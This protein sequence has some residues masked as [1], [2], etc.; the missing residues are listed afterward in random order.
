LITPR[1]DHGMGAAVLIHNFLKELR[2]SDIRFF[3]SNLR[4]EW[5]FGSNPVSANSHF[6]YPR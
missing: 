6:G 1:I 2:N 5:N 3:E 4:R